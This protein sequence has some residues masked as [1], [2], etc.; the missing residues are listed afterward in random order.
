MEHY[1]INSI[2]VGTLKILNPDKW[3]L[4]KNF[5]YL[6]FL[7]LPTFLF[8]TGNL[9]KNTQGYYYLYNSDPSYE[10]LINSLNLA[11]LKGYGVGHIDHPGTSVQVIGA[12]VLKFYYISFNENADIVT[13]VITN[14]EMYLAIFDKVLIVMNSLTLLGLGCLPLQCRRICFWAFW[15]SFLRLHQHRCFMVCI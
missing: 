3:N 10:Y 15:L 2:C 8:L 11:Q 4:K 12:F 7:V 13:H 6:L 14:P 1:E 5:T 9:L